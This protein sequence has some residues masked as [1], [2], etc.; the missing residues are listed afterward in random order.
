M[1]SVIIVSVFIGLTQQAHTIIIDAPS[2]SQYNS[3]YFQYPDTLSCP[4]T[5]IA[6]V[7]DAFA[8]VSSVNHPLCS[9]SF[10]S[11]DAWTYPL[12]TNKTWIDLDIFLLVTQFRLL[13]SICKLVSEETSPGQW[14]FSG[15]RL[16]S[17]EIV[18]RQ[19]FESQINSTITLFIEDMVN[20]F[21]RSLVFISD[22]FRSNQLQ[23]LYMTN[24]QTTFSTAT[25]NYILRSIPVSYNNGTC[26][27]AAG[28]SN[29]SRSLIFRDLNSNVITFPGGKHRVFYS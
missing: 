23:N 7:Y 15:R 17:L 29:C 8:D 25:E 10:P 27:C 21:H 3:L 24:W 4:C 18:S 13:S 5:N 2:E 1:L 19:S 20:K 26:I 12:Y 6:I 9:D 28:M 11:S 14:H 22:T 16:I